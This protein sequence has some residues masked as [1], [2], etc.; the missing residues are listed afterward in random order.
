MAVVRGWARLSEPLHIEVVPV[1]RIVGLRWRLLIDGTGRGSPRFDEDDLPET[2]HLGAFAGEELVGCLTM[3][4][5]TWQG[6]PAWQLRGMAV[7][8]A[9]RKQK[10]GGRLLEAAEAEAR[11]RSE[12]CW[13][14]CKAREEAIVFYR[15]A[16]WRIESEPFE[17]AGITHVTMSRRLDG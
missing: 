9:Y 17:Y 3:L 4:P 6:E 8:P 10:I 12:A 2:F 15:R 5:S 7:E 14:W 13:I 16:G 1:E 11:G